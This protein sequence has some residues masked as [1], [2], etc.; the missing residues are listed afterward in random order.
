MSEI[1][2]KTI[3]SQEHRMLIDGEL[4]DAADAAMLDTINP[5]NGQVIKQF[6]DASGEDLDRA[7]RSAQRAQPEWA[8]HTLGDRQRCLGE[9]AEILRQYSAELGALDSLE[10]GN[11]YS[12]MR[13]DAEGGAF[14][15]D[16][17]CGIANELKGESTQVDNSLHYTRLEPYGVVAKLLPF[18]H[19]IQSLGSGIAAPL[20]T[21]NTVILKPSPHT[22]LSALRFG[23]LVKDVVP[24]GVINVVSGSNSRA[25]QGL[26]EHP[27]IPRMSVTG[28][29]EVG[30]MALRLG[31]ESLKT[32][33]LELGGKTPMIIFEDADLEL[34][35]A[36]A[37]RGMN[38][39]WQ[40]H[41]CTST[42]RVL[43]H[44]SLHDEF[45]EE[46]AKRVRAVNVAMPFDPASEMG[47]ISHRAQFR[48]V[49]EY[50]ESGLAEGAT[51][52]CGG[53]PILDSDM[54][55]GL[56]ISPAIFS[57]ATPEMRIAREEIYGPVITV[58]KW[59]VDEE[60]LVIANSVPYGLAA[61]I[62]GN[63]LSRVHRMASRLECGYVEV[64][65]PVSFS[66]GSPFGGVKS[67]GTGREGSMQEL[68]SYTQLKSINV[69]L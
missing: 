52:V 12:H 22:A 17:F 54:A 38:F 20:L 18:N 42:S 55:Q 59:K 2:L 31:A 9:V 47:P 48:K 63:D 3:V 30:K 51:L 58:L 60:A 6:P 15:V 1:N 35:L 57:D 7:V 29:T 50:I 44:E 10:N 25:A 43:V 14:M 34:S 65:G 21:G 40:G 5:A 11:V 56:F 8:S 33:T 24:R 64:N 4:C 66:L 23:E 67:S 27:G 46:L 36:T 53:N 62:M 26:M 28:S 32:T 61:V 69:R 49:M 16:Y 39:K 41:S 37:L 45:I 19:P 13:H 68:L